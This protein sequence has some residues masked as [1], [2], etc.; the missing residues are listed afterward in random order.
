MSGIISVK[1]RIMNNLSL[2]EY[3]I[4][5]C[6]VSYT[7]GILTF[8]IWIERSGEERHREAVIEQEIAAALESQY[9]LTCGEND[10]IESIKKLS[11]NGIHMESYDMWLN[12]ER[13]GDE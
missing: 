5:L 6:A 2:R 3:L 11:D 9:N 7:L 13:D 4:I 8:G 12:I 10:L 1:W